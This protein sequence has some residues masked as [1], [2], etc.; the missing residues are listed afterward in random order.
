MRDVNLYSQML[1]LSF[2]RA[3][4]IIIII[5]SRILNTHILFFKQF[6]VSNERDPLLKI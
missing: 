6:T 3:A 2:I 1:S 5:Y 4:V